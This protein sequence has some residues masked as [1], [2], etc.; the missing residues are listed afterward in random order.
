L[1]D[2]QEQQRRG[3][4]DRGLLVADILAF[5]C[6]FK[7][8]AHLYQKCRQEQKALNMYTDLRMFDL[9]QVL[10]LLLLL[11]IYLNFKWDFTCWQ[12]YSI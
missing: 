2:P 4:K 10:L 8:A 3:E 1:C 6:R 5:C 9:A 7:E 11:F 12:W